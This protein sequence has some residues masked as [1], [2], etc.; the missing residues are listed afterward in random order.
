MLH[1]HDDSV[2]AA[3]SQITDHGKRRTNSGQKEIVDRNVIDKISNFVDNLRMDFEDS[4]QPSTSRQSEVNV[5]GQ[6]EARRKVDRTL[7]EAEK[8][9]A[10]INEPPG[11][12]Q[13]NSKE[14]KCCKSTQFREYNE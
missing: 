7:I 13:I 8:F 9:K 2:E 3:T 14:N 1:N 12:Y 10:T 4:N 11:T 5:P 6:D